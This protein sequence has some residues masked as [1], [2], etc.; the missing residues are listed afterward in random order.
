MPTVT[1][2]AH[3]KINLWLTVGEKRP[4]G[5]HEIE[6]VMQ[7]ISL[8]DLVTVTR[9][10]DG[11]GKRIAV[12]C[13]DPALPT[14]R[15]NIVWKCAEAFLASAGIEAY[16]IFI[17]IEKHIP[18]SAGLAGGSA[19]GAAVLSLLNRLFGVRAPLSVLSETGA[20]VGADIPFC[21]AGG[22]RIC[23]GK[24]EFL[25]PAERS[26]ALRSRA[27]VIVKNPVL[28]VSTAEAYRMLDE[29]PSSPGD[30]PLRQ[31]GLRTLLSEI[32]SG[33]IPRTLYND[34]ERIAPPEV[35]AMKKKLLALGAASAL[36]SGSGPAVCGLFEGL[37]D[38]E[39]ARDALRTDGTDAWAVR[40]L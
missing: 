39:A 30:A 37:R 3:A 40:L 35:F 13:S 7:E 23:R 8:C 33:E 18:S 19:D 20:G 5:Y 26:P 34:F 11:D 2:E 27:A 12:H 31:N 14:D 4:D 29:T 38:A 21:L 15:R 22:T 24:G 9:H 17:D 36:M 10:P 32:R 28:S 6:S 25:T 1:T 16:D